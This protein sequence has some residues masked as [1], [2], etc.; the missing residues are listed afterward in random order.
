M[1]RA[2]YLGLLK[3]MTGITQ[4]DLESIRPLYESE[5]AEKAAR[6]LKEM[7]GEPLVETRVIISTYFTKLPEA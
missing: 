4:A 3:A 7:S 2:E 1:D 6:K 5:G